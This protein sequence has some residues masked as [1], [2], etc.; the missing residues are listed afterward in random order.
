MNY[1]KQL[2]KGTEIRHL[3]HSTSTKPSVTWVRMNLT[4]VSLLERMEACIQ[5]WTQV[6]LIYIYVYIYLFIY[7]FLNSGIK[8]FQHSRSHFKILDSGRATKKHVPHWGPTD[9]RSHGTKFG[10]SVDLEQ[11]FL[12]LHVCYVSYFSSRHDLEQFTA[13]DRD[14]PIMGRGTTSTQFDTVSVTCDFCT[15]LDGGIA[16]HVIISD[17]QL[18]RVSLWRHFYRGPQLRKVFFGGR[19]RHGHCLLICLVDRVA[20]N[21]I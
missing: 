20:I 14:P 15:L 21:W 1:F 9:I 19:S 12:H 3:M 5:S 6:I 18:N 17:L 11:G 13:T 8:F 2:T 4:G 16:L 7:L 10:R